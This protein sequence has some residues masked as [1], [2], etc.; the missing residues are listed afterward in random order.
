MSEWLPRMKQHKRQQGESASLLAG[1]CQNQ[2]PSYCRLSNNDNVNEGYSS[3]TKP[4]SISLSKYGNYIPFDPMHFVA[5][6]VLTSQA[7]ERPKLISLVREKN[8]QQYTFW[9]IFVEICQPMQCSKSQN[10]TCHIPALYFV[11]YLSI[12]R[13]MLIQSK[14][15]DKLCIR[16]LQ[17]AEE[18]RRGPWEATDCWQRKLTT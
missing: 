2:H 14:E 6:N 15:L 13:S 12:L 3:T 10:R 4:L 16:L 9:P 18:I 17:I 11:Q 7:Q 5:F 1:A 8:W